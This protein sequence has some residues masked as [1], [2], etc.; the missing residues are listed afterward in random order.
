MKTQTY[1]LLRA[2]QVALVTALLATASHAQIYKWTDEDGNVHFGDKPADAQTASDAEQV[3]IELNYQPAD[4]SDEERQRLLAEQNARADAARNRREAGELA[5]AKQKASRDEEKQGRCRE[6][7]VAI[8]KLGTADRK[9]GRLQR[10]F[11]EGEDGQ[12]ISEEE[13][14]AIVE[15]LRRE[16]TA[17]GC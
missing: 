10:T 14:N 3:D 5:A 1:A 9:Y 8:Q 17:L 15:D 13:Q 2:T 12:S 7:D 11:I 6:L 4:L 16:R